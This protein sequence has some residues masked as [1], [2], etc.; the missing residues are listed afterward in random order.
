L[1]VALLVGGVC[2]NATPITGRLILN[3]TSNS[4]GVNLTTT[5][6][7]YAGGVPSD[8]TFGTFN[9]GVGS[10]MSF[11]AFIGDSGLVRSFNNTDVPLGVPTSYAN[12]IQ[13]PTP[14]PT[15]EFVLTQLI[16]GS[17][18]MADCTA[19]PAPGQTCT[20]P[21]PGGSPIELSNS[22]N[23]TG[24]INTHADFNVDVQAIN[25]LTGETSNGVGTFSTD[26]SN[27]SLQ[28]LLSTVLAGGTVTSGFGGD[29]TIVFSSTTPEPPT[30]LFLAGGL[31]VLGSTVRR[32]FG[33][34]DR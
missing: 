21:I 10:T 20:P 24:G 17:F 13:I 27:T 22:S 29:F 26:F 3:A 34:K 1:F 16:P 28:Q 18:G 9:I 33:R 23:G 4:V 14:T 5:D 8:L 12:F 19:A 7:N 11:A 32:K 6:F 30:M 31:L 15:I 25:L 2:L